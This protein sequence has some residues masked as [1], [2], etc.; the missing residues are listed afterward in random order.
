MVAQMA[1][2]ATVASYKPVQAGHR[3]FSCTCIKGWESLPAGETMAKERE[4]S[5]V[6]T[7]QGKKVSQHNRCDYL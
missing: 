7:S 1:Q 2:K 4:S 6:K 5:V 3:G